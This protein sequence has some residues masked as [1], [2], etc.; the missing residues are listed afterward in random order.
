MSE[1]GVSIPHIRALDGLRGLAIVGVLLFHGGHL[2]GGFLGVD[3]FFVLSGFLITS[4]LLAEHSRTDRIALGA[5][6]ARRARRLLPALVLVLFFVALY[7][8]VWA[9]PTAYT[10]IRDDALATLGYVA[11]WRAIA[12]GNDYFSLFASQS[13]LEH[14]WSLAIEEQFYVVWPL[15]FFGI[16]AWWHRRTA[17][18]VLVT[19]LV[20]G[21]TST[22]LMVLLYKA[23]DTSRAYYGT[24]TRAT[25]L[26]AG[27][28][29]AAAIALWG[30]VRGRVLRV[31]L[32]VTAIGALGALAYAW[33]SVGGGFPRL[34]HGGF[35][36]TGIA[37]AVIILAAI[38]PQ[39][40]P[41]AVALSFPPL[42]WLGLIS[43]GLYLWHWPIDVILY[44]ARAGFNGWP[45]FATQSAVAIAIATASYV[46]VEAPIRHGALRPRQWRWIAPATA[47]LLVGAIFAATA[48]AKSIQLPDDDTGRAAP[49]GV[50]VV[51]DSVARTVAPGLD[52]R[53]FDVTNEGANAC[54]LMVGK[55]RGGPPTEPCPWHQIFQRNVR[56]LKPGVV[57][58][59]QGAF[60]LLDIKPPGSPRWFIP[61]DLFWANYY[62]ATLETAVKLLTA[63]GA[64]VVIPS[65]PCMGSPI[66]DAKI[67]EASQF[68]VARV[69]AANAVIALVARKN[70]KVTAPDLFSFLCPTGKYQ[71]SL[72]GVS[73]VRVDGVHFS[74][75]GSDLVA[76]FLAP[77][78]AAVKPATIAR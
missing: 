46:L 54:R 30:H 20:L 76:S 34:Y 31:A 68:N 44:P 32:E 15:A 27:I 71:D 9:D 24:D 74:R 28:A 33:T 50:L 6:W 29:V 1:R 48:G 13:P 39:R 7:A 47:V 62:K 38:H 41:I 21:A 67:A 64:N 18:A 61:G 17:A 4:L 55:I 75:A 49:G 19:A 56:V 35:L 59:V 23:A 14:T 69:R 37:A 12:V 36:A 53:G 51:G 78:I 22:G 43:Y 5:F 10:T 70:P 77:A 16:A 63:T 57:V 72:N 26:F 2:R 66:L 58:L 73:G 25:A 11:N 52:R 65:I 8:V 40:G 45:L 60:E 3:L 42:C